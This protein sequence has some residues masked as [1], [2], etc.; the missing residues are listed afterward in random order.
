MSTTARSDAIHSRQQTVIGSVP[1]TLP[2]GAPPEGVQLPLGP[3]SIVS[4][5]ELMAHPVV[6]MQEPS[7]GLV[8]YCPV[9]PPPSYHLTLPSQ[10]ADAS[11][12]HAQAVHPR[13]SS[14]AS[15]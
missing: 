1:F 9:H 3:D 8:V 4:L 10:P 14:N 5:A 12:E 13:V 7:A 2:V 11:A 6:E 15:P